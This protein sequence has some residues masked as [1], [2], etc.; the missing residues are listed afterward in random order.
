MQSKICNLSFTCIYMTAIHISLNY[1]TQTMCAAY[2]IQQDQV[3]QNTLI[4]DIYI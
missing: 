2:G 1:N 3:L 4:T